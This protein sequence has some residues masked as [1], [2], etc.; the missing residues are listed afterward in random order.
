MTSIQR[1]IKYCAIA[2]SIFIII[3][4]ISAISFSMYMLAN[5]LGLNKEKQTQIAD[6]E[7]IVT[8]FEEDSNIATLNIKLRVSNL[9]IK[10]G[11]ILRAESNNKN[12]TCKQNNNKLVIEEKNNNWFSRKYE[13]ELI[14][15]IPENIVFET[16]K[17]ET[18]AGD[19]KIEKINTKNLSLEVGAGK[20]E[21]KKLNVSEQA[22]IEGGAGKVE[23]LSGDI[24]NL[25]LNMGIGKFTINTKLIGNN[26]IDAGIGK[27]D[28]NLNNKKEDYTIKA[29]KG[30]GTISIDENQIMD[31]KNY[32]EG[33]NVIKVD[34]GI[35]S[36]D[37]KFLEK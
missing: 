35:G 29:N 34:G 17:I 20:V 13:N 12:I 21:I 26:K 14:V 5:I 33:N 22:N 3:N 10:T 37:I 15:Y 24:H 6:S 9:V 32:G 28:I 30:I 31:D 16:I 1:V 8:N 4:I 11:D 18:G 7:K 23:I 19:I 2:L 27:L 36:I 25:N